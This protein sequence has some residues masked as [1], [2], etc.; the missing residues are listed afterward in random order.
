[1]IARLITVVLVPLVLLVW[2]VHIVLW[3]FTGRGIVFQYMD[4]LERRWER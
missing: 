2:P 1:M 4:W 3:V